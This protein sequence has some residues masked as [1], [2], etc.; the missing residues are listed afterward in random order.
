MRLFTGE[1]KGKLQRP[2]GPKKRSPLKW[3]RWF[4]ASAIGIICN[5][6][7][8]APDHVWYLVVAPHR[9]AMLL[10]SRKYMRFFLKL[11][12]DNAQIASYPSTM[13]PSTNRQ[14]SSLSVTDLCLTLSSG[15]PTKTS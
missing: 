3:M 4:G 8:L 1:I 9:A 13:R 10:F 5:R 15:S 7:N 6:K 14:L 11:P 2:Y 12:I